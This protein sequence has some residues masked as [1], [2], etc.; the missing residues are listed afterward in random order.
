[1]DTNDAYSLQSTAAYRAELIQ[2][3]ARRIPNPGT[4]E[5]A[6]APLKVIRMDAPSELI[7]TVHRP[8]LCLIVQGRKEI[9]LGEEKY[10]YDPLNYFVVSVTLPVFGR[11]IEASA[12]APYI[13]IRLDFDPASCGQ[14]S[15][16]GER[17]HVLADSVPPFGLYKMAAPE[18]A[19]KSAQPGCRF[20]HRM[21]GRHGHGGS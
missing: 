10:C 17:W 19:E 5:T 2:I 12:E 7:Y 4:H 14:G 1:M 15:R 11:V 18:V 3:L 8:A 6:I 20:R 9:G 13:C 21:G 16:Q